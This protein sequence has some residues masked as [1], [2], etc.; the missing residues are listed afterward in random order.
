MIDIKVQLRAAAAEFR[1]EST[2]NLPVE[3]QAAYLLIAHDQEQAADEIE[4]LEW[5]ATM[6]TDILRVASKWSAAHDALD[7]AAQH[8]MPTKEDHEK[9]ALAMLELRQAV[10]TN[11]YTLQAALALNERHRVGP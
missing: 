9:V 1:K 7:A 8:R 5:Y 2:K 3:L 10:R 4:R 6:G 11:W